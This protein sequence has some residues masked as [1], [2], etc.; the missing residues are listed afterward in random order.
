MNTFSIKSPDEPYLVSCSVCT[1]LLSSNALGKTNQ[2]H[3]QGDSIEHLELA[4]N[5]RNLTPPMR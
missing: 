1:S 2:N 4:D 3:L 5:E